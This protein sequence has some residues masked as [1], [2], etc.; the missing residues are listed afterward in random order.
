MG[1]TMNEPKP[2]IYSDGS[3]CISAAIVEELLS[4]MLKPPQLKPSNQT[5]C[6][7]PAFFDAET[8]L[9]IEA[10]NLPF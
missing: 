2:T 4:K 3:N 9:N 5:Q 10:G 1:L 6:V 8:F 7:E